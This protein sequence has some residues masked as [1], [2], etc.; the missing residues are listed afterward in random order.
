MRMRIT[1][2][3]PAALAAAVALSGCAGGAG[4]PEIVQAAAGDTGVLRQHV[5]AA[6][7][8]L[9]EVAERAAT[10]NV[11]G[12]REAYQV[13][14][15]AFGQVLGPMSFRD[16]G[17]AQQMANA[18][19]ALQEQLSQRQLNREKV[20]QEA[21]DLTLAMA[22][23]ARTLGFSLTATA[24]AE[25]GT[26]LAQGRVIDIKATEYRF[27]PARI[28]VKKGEPVTIRFTNVGKEKH[29][30]EMDSFG[31]EIKAI[32]PGQ[33]REV[34]FTPDKTGTFEYAC[35]VDE[36]Y[37]KGMFGFLLVR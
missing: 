13:F 5:T 4:T 2:L 10:G 7:A 20:A 35:H 11:P 1:V 17:L 23:A 31:Q 12:T 18:N 26:D 28:E 8:A 32:E 9:H 24:S 30:W 36:H 21:E 37:E 19:T 15:T 14:A 22:Q 33:T 6:A 29:E 34:T 3:F 25:L 16:S 27:E